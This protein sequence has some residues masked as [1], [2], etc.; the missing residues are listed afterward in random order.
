MA[1]FSTPNAPGRSVL[2]VEEFWGVDYT[3]SPAGVDP[4]RSPDA[5]NM[6]RD[7]PGK[8]RKSMG[9]QT[10]KSYP[11][12]I[13]GVHFRRSDTQGLVHAGAR[14]YQ[15]DTL[16]YSAANDERSRSW[17]FG[18]C[19]YILDGKALLEWDGSAVRPVTQT[20]Y[21]P[22]L[23]IARPPTGGG[24]A[25]ED[26]NLL[27]PKFTE[28]FAGAAGAT[29]YHLSFGGLDSAPVTVRL[30]Q[31]DGSWAA[32]TENTHFTVDR[33]A[34]IVTFAT[35]PGASP[36]TGEDN[37]EI[38]ASRTV[39]GYADRI[40]RCRIG[41]LFGVNGAADRLFV[42]GN[43]DFVNYDWYC[44][45]NDPTYWPDTGYSVL[46]TP[47]SAI[48]GYSVVNERLAAHK[49]DREDGRNVIIRQGDLAD[50]K[51]SFPIVNTLQGQGAVAPFSFAYLVNEPLFLTRSGVYAITA[52]DLTGEK[53]TQ[54]RSFYL[55]GRLLE[56]PGLEDAFALVYKDMYWL[57]LNG[58]AYILDGLQP[59]QTD[60]AA[61]YATRQYVG[62]HRTNLP[63]RVLW[64]Q[65]DALWF[66]TGDGR[67]CRFATDPALLAS[68]NDDGAAI[69]CHWDT[70]D[71]SGKRFYKNKT[72]RRV[73]V[74][75]SSAVATGVRLWMQHRGVW[76]EMGSDALNARYF[77]WDQ[78]DWSRFS[79]SGDQTPRLLTARVRL[80]RVD[81]TRLR[82]EN[83]QLN[84]PFGLSELALEFA[85]MGDCRQ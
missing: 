9:W 15:G 47:R 35:A 52:Q 49:D 17:Q 58:Q 85:E 67:I 66:G 16:L 34:G 39:A 54:N 73:M 26:L 8:V 45:Q 42:A 11:A 4:R 37:V 50:S 76:R 29:A 78:L 57:A 43:P 70:P 61:P 83:D 7:V 28:R 51:A 3:N 48:V 62:F 71:L 6:I 33:A 5:P 23:T 82:L 63:A 65:E 36:V 41:A 68:Y 79:W 14:L 22:I 20:A 21:V 2:T 38:T 46:G 32:R 53:Y 84:E 24:V 10:V 55:N 56:E 30:L 12:R 25:Y 81:K 31:A 64:E 75:L 44:G 72:F 59:M 69:A 13:N 27:Q 80:R 19:L 1:Y 18:D 77:T 74:R 60:P 40:G